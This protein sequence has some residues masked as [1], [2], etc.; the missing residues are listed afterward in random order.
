MGEGGTLQNSDDEEIINEEPIYTDA[1]DFQEMAIRYCIQSLKDMPG[2]KYIMLLTDRVYIGNDNWGNTLWGQVPRYKELAEMALQ[3]G[4][5]V[6]LLSNVPVGKVQTNRAFIPFSQRTGGLFYVGWNFIFDGIR[7]A[8][9]MTKGYYLLSYIPPEK[10]F[11]KANND[12]Y[13]NIKVKVERKGATVHTRDGFYAVPKVANKSIEA[14]PPPPLVEIM[15]SPFNNNDLNINLTS[16][17]VDNLSEGYLLP[18]WM[19]LDGRDLRVIKEEDAHHSVSFEVGASTTDIDG[20]FQDYGDIK[21]EFLVDE[22]DIEKLRKN[23]INFTISIPV[24]KPG[25]YYVRA[26]VRDLFSDAKGSAYQFIEIPDLK[27]KRLALS[28]LYIIDGEEDASWIRSI[29]TD[30]SSTKPSEDS[31]RVTFR[32]PAHKEFQPGD[33]FEY[34]TVIYNA[35]TKKENPPDLES[36]FVLYRDGVKLYKSEV[37]AIEPS[38]VSDFKRIPIQRKLHLEDSMQPGDYVLQFLVKDNNAKEKE[39]LTAQTLSFRVT[40]K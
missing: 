31:K 7:D 20:I 8:N 6:H 30:T 19:H 5:V 38:G 10:T 28:S 29:A 11:S 40:V 18:T 16:G 1:P 35:K 3:A 17:Y 4:V 37:E 27:K 25:G 36:Q 2:Q 12:K 39:S 13:H 14:L 34:M 22:A 26:A 33:S 24:K 32:N 21:I 23:G 9:E 15:F